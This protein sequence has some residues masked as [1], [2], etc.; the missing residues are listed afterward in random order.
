MS[1]KVLQLVLSAQDN[2]ATRAVRGLNSDLSKTGGQLVDME[3]KSLKLAQSMSAGIGQIKALLAIGAII[4]GGGA[5]LTFFKQ[6]VDQLDEF[7]EKARVLGVIP[8]ELSL[9]DLAA[10]RVNVSLDDLA[11]GAV[12]GQRSIAKAVREGKGEALDA[13]REIG[14]SAVNQ[15]GQVR[16]MLELLPEIGKALDAKGYGQAE[17]QEFL[18]RIF[19]KGGSA[20]ER[21]IAS[22]RDLAAMYAELERYNGF[23]RQK[24]V[25]A[26]QRV[27]DSFDRIAISVRGLKAA[28]LTEAAPFLET[29]VNFA[30]RRVGEA[31]DEVRGVLLALRRQ[32]DGDFKNDERAGRVVGD[33]VSTGL[34]FAAETV[35]ELAWMAA[36]TFTEAM[37]SGIYTLTPYV[38]DMVNDAITPYWNQTFGRLPGVSYM[39]LSLT[40]QAAKAQAF[41]RQSDPRVG[42]LTQYEVNERNRSRVIVSMAQSEEKMR[43]QD[44]ASLLS[45]EFDYLAAEWS[46]SLGRIRSKLGEFTGALDAAGGY[47]RQN[48]NIMIH[49]PWGVLNTSDLESMAL[50]RGVL[51]ESGTPP[52]L[53]PDTLYPDRV[54]KQGGPGRYGPPRP[55]AEDDKAT[56]EYVDMVGGLTLRGVAANQG[57]EAAARAELRIKHQQELYEIQLKYGEMV[58]T[59][60]SPTLQRLHQDEEAR[61]ITDQRMVEVKRLTK[62][63]E[64]AYARAI[65]RTQNLVELGSI[66]QLQAMRATY[67]A[68]EQM[69]AAIKKDIVVLEGLRSTNPEI[70]REVAQQ[71]DEARQRL[72]QLNFEMER[73]R[74]RGDFGAGMVSVLGDVEERATDLYS[75]GRRIGDE[76]VNMFAVSLPNAIAQTDLWFKSLF[77][78]GVSLGEQFARTL[79]SIA[80]QM[81]AIRAIQGIASLWSGPAT[82]GNSPANFMAGS[83]GPR[84]AG[85]VAGAGG[86]VAG[87][88]GL[89]PQRMGPGMAHAQFQS[90]EGGGIVGN[91]ADVN[92]DTVVALLARGEPV[93]NRRARRRTTDSTLRHMNAGGEVVPRGAGAGG[94]VTI[95]EI[96]IHMTATPGSD[97]RQMARALA[98]E[99]LNTLER[100]VGKRQQY[101]NMLGVRGA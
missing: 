22:G 26:A 5:V 20:I 82:A 77:R 89:V 14:V 4:Q 78:S 96:H 33:L 42:A 36:V 92:R 58:A 23:V 21:L 85:S 70:D 6:I 32:L 48:Q 62:D 15:A 91:G 8:E 38:G 63:S 101:R 72:A 16:S 75:F 44:R 74:R 49:G 1:Q 31:P 81:L 84:F 39:D 25:D 29:L 35:K 7:G 79:A 87:M 90:F 11:G 60:L 43:R 19:G 68:Q 80:L 73:F 54:W 59:Y 18:S 97:P 9:W 71:I 28:A 12:K 57:P 3:R 55:T 98:D 53:G 65:Q 95:G 30:S 41:I 13:L 50:R 40:G 56:R 37:R 27:A 24:D 61:L 86:G 46:Q 88:W 47:Y 69:S 45:Q 2:G 64:D 99:L 83:T 76:T 93:L 17:R 94:A 67:A 34:G 51:H 10:R 52:I 100:D 66:T